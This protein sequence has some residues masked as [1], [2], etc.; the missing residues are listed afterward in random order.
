MLFRLDPDKV[1][2]RMAAVIVI[3]LVLSVI[4]VVGNRL[5]AGHW[6][7]ELFYLDIEGNLP[8]WAQSMMLLACSALLVWAGSME[9]GDPRDKRH[10]SFLALIFFIMSMDEMIA[11]HER[12]IVPMSRVFRAEGGGSLFHAWVIAWLL[13]SLPFLTFIFISSVGFLKRLPKDARH[14]FLTAGIVYLLGVL[15]VEM[16]GGWFRQIYGKAGWEYILAVHVEESLEMLGLLI[17]IRA[18]LKYIII[19]AG[20]DRFKLTTG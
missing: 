20:T 19:K 17:F 8:S 18:L 14:G 16:I 5:T 11:V 13:V 4:G 15:G 2:R 10:W 12:F 7:G 1:T 3:L 9:T 6:K